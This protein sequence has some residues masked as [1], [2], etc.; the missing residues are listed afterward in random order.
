M[1][2]CWC[3]LCAQQHL[4]PYYLQFRRL[5][6]NTQHKFSRLRFAAINNSAATTLTAVFSTS[7][8]FHMLMRTRRRKVRKHT[9][10]SSLK[11]QLPNPAQRKVGLPTNKQA[12]GTAALSNTMLC[13]I[14]CI[15]E[16]R[17]NRKPMS[18]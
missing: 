1:H 8:M 18:L 9:C 7:T 15:P 4:M 17:N 13:T 10:T 3:F 12:C 14:R 11:H 5:R 2:N 6:H 16:T